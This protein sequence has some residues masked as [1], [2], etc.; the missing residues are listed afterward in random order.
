[1]IKLILT[2]MLIDFIKEINSGVRKNS[3]FSI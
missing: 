3:A 2:S 1:M